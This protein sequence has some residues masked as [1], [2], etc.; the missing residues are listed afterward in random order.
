VK[1]QMWL[2]VFFSVFYV[3]GFGLL[4]YGLWN[5]WRSNQA[6]TWPRVPAT[7]TV[8]EVREV[9]D[10]DNTT[11]EVHVRYTYTVNEV[12]YEGSRLCFGY[13][14]ST[15]RQEQDE[16]FQRLKEAKA[17]SARYHPANPSLSCLFCGLHGSTPILLAFAL[18]WLLFVFGF[19]A[20]VRAILEMESRVAQ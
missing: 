2:F 14:G 10:S 11:Y 16:I 19:H 15:E 7:L 4:G 1:S 8:L 13:W 18:G 5:A 9:S 6:T 12:V 20:V 17:V 3:A